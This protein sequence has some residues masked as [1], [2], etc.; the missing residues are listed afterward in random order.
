MLPDRRLSLAYDGY[1]LKFD[2]TFYIWRIT[3]TNAPR[4]PVELPL[5]NDGQ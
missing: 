4:I 5:P 1:D 2:K 3:G